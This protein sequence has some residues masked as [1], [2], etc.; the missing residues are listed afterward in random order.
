MG[1][2]SGD[3]PRRFAPLEA[4][5]LIAAL[6]VLGITV[7]Y[8]QLYFFRAPNLGTFHPSSWEVLQVDHRCKGPNCLEVGDRLLRIGDVTHDT[9]LRAPWVSLPD[10]PNGESVEIELVRDGETKIVDVTPS[11]HEPGGRWVRALGANALPLVFWLA[12]TIGLLFVRPLDRRGVL[13]VGLFYCVALFIASGLSS[14]SHV[15]YSWYALTLSI[16]LFVPLTLH[17]HLTVPIRRLG[18]QRWL[19]GT[20]YLAAGVGAYLCIT[21]PVANRFQALAFLVAL[22]SSL[23]LLAWGWM[24]ST[25]RARQSTRI[26]TAGAFLGTTPLFLLAVIP[27]LAPAYISEISSP[28]DSLLSLVAIGTIPLWPFSYLY[29]VHR[30][31][32]PELGLRANRLLGI[33]GFYA[34][35]LA[36]FLSLQLMIVRTLAMMRIDE[37]TRLGGITTALVAAS[38]LL[39]VCAPALQRRFQSWLDRVV[40]GLRYRPEE[41]INVLAQ[42]IP[43]AVTPLKLQSI[44]EDEILPTFLIR[45]SALYLVRGNEVETI[46]ARDEE[47]R[48]SAKQLSRLLESPGG[49][50]PTTDGRGEG[51]LDW[52]KLVLPL[53]TH[54]ETLGVWLFGARDPDDRYPIHDVELLQ[55]LANMVAAVVKGQQ[56]NVAKSRFLANMSH[57]IRTPMGGVLGMVE[58][59]TSTD[60][61][62]RQKGYVET[63]RRSATSL[64]DILNDVL[65][66]SK[67]EAG[68]LELETVR[69]DLHQ[70]I[71]DIVDL[72]GERAHQKGLDLSVERPG[73]L[74]STLT[75]DP[76]RLRQILSNLVG[77]AIKFTDRGEVTLQICE[78]GREDDCVQLEFRVRDTG[79]GIEKDSLAHLFESFQQADGSTTRK[80]GGTGLGLA[81]ARQLVELMQGT[82]GVDSVVGSGSTFWFRVDLETASVEGEDEQ[83]VR[84]GEDAV[85]GS[86]V[87]RMSTARILVV[88]DNPVMSD[89]T[90]SMIRSLG[91]F[92]EIV[93]N[94]RE[95]LQA[96]LS[97]DFDLVLMDCQ[98][99]VM[100]GYE[101]TRAIRSSFKV[102]GLSRELVRS[103]PPT[104]VAMTA[105]AM[106]GDR[107]RCLEAGMDDYISKPFTLKALE[108]LLDRWLTSKTSSEASRSP[109]VA[110]D[111]L[112]PASSEIAVG[113]RPE[114]P[115]STA[116]VAS[117]G[118]PVD[119]AVLEGIR[120]LG[121]SGDQ[122]LRKI[123]SRFLESTPGLI[124]TLREAQGSGDSETVF[125]T[126][127]SLKSSSGT[128]GAERLTKLCGAIASLG[129]SD[130]LEEVEPLL[131]KLT[132]EYEAVELVLKEEC[133]KV[134]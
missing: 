130:A 60:L 36:T 80:Y 88:E 99:P 77:N 11:G 109:A 65:D 74:P 45:Q 110:D 58:L 70:L 8:V 132:S 44:I 69:F 37:N 89:V 71:D 91:G 107:E 30:R 61:T 21:D 103:S 59:L 117:D 67:I 25:G 118:S 131:A 15:G 26:M 38:A 31:Q 76:T 16:W 68:K 53:S 85:V 90:A 73:D 97:R 123:V 87:E 57:E 1:V 124:A 9:Y 34:V 125:Q 100:D 28:V 5:R 50:S 20:T 39:V 122:L 22:S 51:E 106:A 105:N 63:A 121:Q 104:I 75:G 86:S 35:F 62:R 19:I 119:V 40:F 3:G 10:L 95:A 14:W 116:D 72:F 32:L 113:T 96:T 82:I 134:A 4:A 33:Y 41:V 54:D 108:E 13:L 114:I 92:V 18:G 133:L 55:N 93:E 78:I 102:Q 98:M 111:A 115:R 2:V 52:V 48:P 56:A 27:S 64:L 66:F 17:F 129:R 94:G 7:F 29:V 127:H 83:K 47:Q 120:C 23:L 101:A 6:L 49:L 84:G 43:T 128:L 12:G 46:H 126:A 112:R 42:R 81:I 24:R 79:V